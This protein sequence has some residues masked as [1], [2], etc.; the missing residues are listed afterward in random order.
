[1]C[2]VLFVWKIN[3]QVITFGS[4]LI[5]GHEKYLSPRLVVP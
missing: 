3:A 5:A 4:S 2:P 1:M